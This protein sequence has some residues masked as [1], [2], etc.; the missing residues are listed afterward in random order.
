[1]EQ[2]KS[3]LKQYLDSGEACWQGIRMKKLC[4]QKLF[5]A[6]KMFAKNFDIKL[7]E[8]VT[9]V[10]KDVPGSD[11]M[12]SSNQLLKVDAVDQFLS[13]IFMCKTWSVLPMVIGCDG[14]DRKK[15]YIR[16][17]YRDSVTMTVTVESFCI[18]GKFVDSHFD[19]SSLDVMGRS[20]WCR[21]HL[22]GQQGG[23]PSRVSACEVA[24]FSSHTL[25]HSTIT[26]LFDEDL[27]SFVTIDIHKSACKQPLEVNGSNVSKV[28][29]SFCPVPG[30]SSSPVFSFYEDLR[31]IKGLMGAFGE[32]K[33]VVWYS[34]DTSDK[35]E[36]EASM[37][38]KVKNFLQNFGKS[39]S[40]LLLPPPNKKS[41][42]KGAV[43]TSVDSTVFARRTELDFTEA[44]WNVTKKC[45]SYEELVG[46]F[47]LVMQRLQQGSTTSYWLHSENKT[48]LAQI[49][50]ASYEK[51]GAELPHLGGSASSLIETHLE[52]GCDF[53]LRDYQRLL[54]SNYVRGA[55]ALTS[56][57]SSSRS[58]EG[59]MTSLVKLHH[60]LELMATGLVV[61]KLKTDKIV[62]LVRSA[63]EWYRTND[64]DF[65]KVFS[66]EVDYK[67]VEKSLL[68][69]T[70]DLWR[71]SFHHQNQQGLNSTP[72]MLVW[73]RDF[74]LG[75]I[76]QDG[77]LDQDDKSNYLST[78]SSTILP[79]A[80]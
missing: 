49:I 20:L 67:D 25:R 17:L 64:V 16:R 14:S 58:W 30:S 80:V 31:I 19:S 56:S 51:Q 76:R 13:M 10:C 75:I 37:V 72:A 53:L 79:A 42:Y 54:H 55:E 43:V 32:R 21:P 7:D 46:C 1:M 8:N 29:V 52:I 47:R 61:T 74:P 3:F 6:S 41:K 36:N 2:F 70:R 65:S 35:K 9:L 4:S 33:E 22:N 34:E 78:L 48:K 62:N 39:A 73:S 27:D 38:D 5:A 57:S 28:V 59:R 11:V 60:V 24:T 15:T 23:L 71:A 18:C 26:S 68:L 77:D 50:R 40:N 44:L 63:I 66:I 45:G 12:L 69:A